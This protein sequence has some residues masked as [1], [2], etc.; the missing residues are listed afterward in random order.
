MK[1]QRRLRRLVPDAELIR[2]R[3][4]DEPLRE[5]ASDYNVSHTTLSRFFERPDVASQLRQTRRER[6]AGE[7]A[8][9]RRQSAERRLEQDV[10]RKA[11]K[12]AAAELEQAR[13]IVALNERA[14][15]RR[16]R[17]DYEA[18]LDL[19]DAR[20]PWTRAD[21]HNGHDQTA[22]RVVAEGGGIEA[23]IE[24]TDLRSLEN[25]VRS[26]DPAI[27]TQAYDNDAI[28]KTKSRGE[29]DA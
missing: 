9:A 1:R 11:K 19:R 21:L 3:A 18:W 29:R 10:R 13:A 4:A 24:A 28:A 7:R 20:V 12:Q 22:A 14:R 16:P 5:L 26:I 23:I 25:V 27:L 15:R 17:T 2:R 8:L 6:Q